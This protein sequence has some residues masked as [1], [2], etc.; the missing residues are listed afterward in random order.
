TVTFVTDHGER[1]TVTVQAHRRSWLPVV[2]G[3]VG[4]AFVGLLA[5]AAVVFGRPSSETLLALSVSPVADRVLVNGQ[6]LGG[7]TTFAVKAP[8]EGQPFQLRV[9]AEGFAAQEEVVTLRSGERTERRVELELQDAMAW[10]P[11]AG[12]SGV[13]APAPVRAAIEAAAPALAPCFAGAPAP[14]EAT[15]TA[16]ITGDGQVRR[17]A[18]AKANF[19][20]EPAEACIRRVFR[21]LRLPSFE[22]NHAAVEARLV[23]QVS[24]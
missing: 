11:P 2:A 1:R 7:G 8:K 9:E 18:V 10:M 21:G 3:V 14:A 12:V 19:P 24:P 17:V 15:Y 4:V 13:D 6:D 23:T 22:G 20:V 5:A 16:W